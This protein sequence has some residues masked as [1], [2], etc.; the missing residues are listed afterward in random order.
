MSDKSPPHN[1]IIFIDIPKQFIQNLYILPLIF[2]NFSTNGIIIPICR[3]ALGGIPI[4]V[5]QR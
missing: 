4:E 2:Q 5:E 3:V 1:L